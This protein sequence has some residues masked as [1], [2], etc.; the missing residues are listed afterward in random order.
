MPRIIN[1]GSCCI[2][3]VFQVPHFV[4]PGET[5][6]STDYRVFPGGK[7]LNQSIAMAKGGA[8][9]IHVGA[10]GHDG[11][12]LQA[13][14]AAAGVDTTYLTLLS[15][16][17][18]QAIIQVDPNGENAIV[19]VGG[20]NQ[21]NHEAELTQ[22]LSDANEQD[23]LLIQNETSGNAFA[24]ALAKRKGLRI[25]FNM[26]P[27]NDSALN[28]PL[29]LVDYFVVNETEAE[30]LTG[31]SA[32]DEICKTFIERFSNSA[33]VLTLGQ[34]GAVYCDAERTI[35]QRAFPV[36]PLDTTGAG[37][38][39]T[40]FLLSHLIGSDQ[41]DEAL[42]IAAAAAALSVTVEGAATSIPTAQAVENFLSQVSLD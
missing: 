31:A 34:D 38:T 39:F 17:S 10:I 19:I 18:G 33:L 21:A 41:V 20:T 36:T 13:E 28:L 22:A 30:A 6:S 5:L 12:W 27:M 16:P 9:V 2:D 26:A 23:M 14:L 40:G 25:V 1:Y 32:P 3:H 8:R 11:Q 42:R 24:M 4:S 7:G 35:T 37:D 29:D 15:T